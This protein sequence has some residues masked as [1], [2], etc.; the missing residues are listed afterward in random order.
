MKV[1]PFAMERWQSTWENRV[2]INLSE[3]G[4]EALRV[5]ELLADSE[6]AALL[7]SRLGYS[8]SNGTEELRGA[9]AAF[10]PGA[11]LDNVVVTI[12]CAEANHLVTWSLVEPGDEVVM[13]VPNYMQTW[14]LTRAFGA[15][16][17]EWRLRPDPAAGRWRADLDEL[18]GLLGPRTRLILLSNPNN[19]TGSCV[20]AEE[21]DEIVRIAAGSGC[22]IL[23]DEVYRGSEVAGGEETASMWGRYDRLLVTG[24]LSKAYGLPGLRIGWVVGPA[25]KVASF[26]GLSDYTTIGPAALSD[27]LATLALR[28]ER[29]RRLLERTR[30]RLATNLPILTRWLDELG[31]EVGYLRPQAGAI[32]YLWYRHRI[33]STKLVERL[34][35]EK[36]VL[37]VAGD[38]F[39]MDGHLRIGYGYGTEHL[40]EGLARIAEV[41]GSVE[42]REPA[43]MK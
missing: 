14:G 3:S 7:D 17:K 36:D 19:P 33:N 1:E 31:D 4:V 21:L 18:G 38:H 12:G 9:V 23:A 40:R 32:L 34:R 6:A 5:R 43:Y 28:P 26:W 16:V 2:E 30:G 13:M 37:V 10:H 11:G 20:P 27:R 42:L 24:G 35:A 8:Q 22:W 25:E 41:L 29:R 39:G 15:E